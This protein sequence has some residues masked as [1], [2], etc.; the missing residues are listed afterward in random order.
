MASLK[1]PCKM[2]KW[3]FSCG[4][5]RLTFGQKPSINPR[6]ERYVSF[7]ISVDWDCEGASKWEYAT[8]VTTKGLHKFLY[9]S[10]CL[11]TIVYS[12]AI[13]HILCVF[14][15]SLDGQQDMCPFHGLLQEFLEGAW[16]STSLFLD[17]GFWVWCQLSQGGIPYFHRVLVLK[18][19][20]TREIPNN[21]ASKFGIQPPCSTLI[22]SFQEKIDGQLANI[23]VKDF[24]VA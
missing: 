17:F 20:I 21:F 10:S 14:H 9:H 2:Q 23:G 22:I 19:G 16:L 7:V 12:L 4:Q 13:A 18:E 24:S 1:I 11:N 15:L 5:K 8:L 3:P 6:C